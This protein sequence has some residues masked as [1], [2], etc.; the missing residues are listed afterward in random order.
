MRKGV[1]A[2]EKFSFNQSQ[3]TRVSNWQRSSVIARMRDRPTK[4]IPRFPERV[5]C[6]RQQLVKIQESEPESRCLL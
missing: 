6:V 4:E 3:E 2:C 1:N 5:V